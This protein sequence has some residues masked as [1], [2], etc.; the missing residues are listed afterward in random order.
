[1]LASVLNSDRAILVNIQIVRVFARM[2][3]LLETHKEILRNLGEL[4]KKD[5]EQDQQ[6]LL[7]FEY[8]KNLEQDKREEHKFK[9][10]RRI[11]FKPEI[12]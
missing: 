7:I 4:Q 8:L 12:P 9:E 6:I 1:M 11:G 10:R 3:R 5:M 2:R